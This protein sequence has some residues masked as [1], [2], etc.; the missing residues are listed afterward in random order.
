MI[1]NLLISLSFFALFISCNSNNSKQKEENKKEEKK[2]SKRD[3]SIN[4]ANAYNNL[5]FDSMVLVKFFTDNKTDDKLIRRM[6]SFYNMRNYQFAWFTNNGLTEQ[7][8]GF[9]NMHNYQTTYANDST[10]KDKN[11]QTKMNAFTGEEDSFAVSPSDKNIITTELKL[12][13][14]FIMF[15]LNNFEDGYV[16]RKEMERFI[17]VKREDALLLA[18]S[19]ISKKH[20]DNKYYE[21]VN[22]TY[23]LLKEQLEKY[24]ALSKQGGWPEITATAKQLKKGSSSPAII[25]IKK[26]LELTGDMVVDTTP[27]FNDMLE[28]GIK[29]FQE[30]FGYTPT[31]TLTDGQI[32]DMNV[33]VLNRI[34]QLLIN[35]GRMQWMINE[36]K[37]QMI[38]VNIPEFILHVKEGT[39]KVFDMNVVVGKEG[40][41]TMMFTGSLNQVVFSPYWN[42][43]ESIVKKEILP[44]I[45]RNPNY[46]AEHHMEIT[47]NEGGLPVIRQLPGEDNSLG[48]VKFLFPNSFNIYFHDTPAKSLFE[49][50]K[51]AYSHG[52]IRLSDPVKMANYLLKDD[53]QW[54]PESI[55]AAMNSGDEK[56]VKLKTPVPVLITY[57]TTW[58]DDNGLLH[59]ADDIYGHDKAVIEKMFVSK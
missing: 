9:W 26:R 32:K 30:R 6:T 53:T 19:L 1:K 57:Y 14:H 46:L 45:E 37:G 3:Y 55:A 33:P 54:S 22:N 59:F 50:D 47:G 5:F 2:I 18:D 13:Q 8:R 34:Q 4:A 29:K 24:Y 10:L 56:Y 52:C 11:L 25:Q 28:A 20:K 12:T 49:K 21:D 58:V 31:G 7:A 23:K 44:A 17:P 35:M 27:I 36:P 41:N 48:K 16:K 42:L 51:R 15:T 43:P 40:H 38:V 39:K